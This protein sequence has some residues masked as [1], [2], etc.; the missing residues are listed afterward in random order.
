MRRFFLPAAYLVCLPLSV[1]AARFDPR[2]LTW[3]L[4]REQAAYL[5]SRVAALSDSTGR[6]LGS[7]FFAYLEERPE[8]KYLVS[9]AHVVDSYKKLD[10]WSSGK[11]L[12]AYLLL[13]DEAHDVAVMAF[14]RRDSAFMPQAVSSASFVLD[15][16]VIWPGMFS[17]SAAY[18]LGVGLTIPGSPALSFGRISQ[19]DAS[20]SLIRLEGLLDLGSSGAPVFTW[21]E[22]DRG[23]ELHL[24]GMA[25]SFQIARCLSQAAG[26]TL[27][28]HSALYEV[29][30]AAYIYNAL[31]KADS[32]VREYSNKSSDD[33]E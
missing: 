25:R 20:D 1:H 16:S 6:F 4:P 26:D 21:I 5:G 31:R 24:V 30:P 3:H 22:Q 17:V 18:P 32:L 29:L 23:R 19:L 9:N 27:V 11:L 7:G 12:K 28:I 2:P 33:I 10:V 14:E 13:K 8:W 15:R